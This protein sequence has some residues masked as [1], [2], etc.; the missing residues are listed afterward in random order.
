[1]LEQVRAK[2]TEPAG[3]DG[4][5]PTRVSSVALVLHSSE[6]ELFLCQVGMSRLSLKSIVRDEGVRR[7]L[8]RLV[9]ECVDLADWGAR[10]DFLATYMAE[11]IDGGLLAKELEQMLNCQVRSE[12]RLEFEELEKI[13]D[14]A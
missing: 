7:F 6:R 13:I 9:G 3:S 14:L 8:S 11:Q 10:L 2:L 1:M 5:A 4:A 12:L